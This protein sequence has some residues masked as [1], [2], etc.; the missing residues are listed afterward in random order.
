MIDDI[1]FY[2][3]PTRFIEVYTRSLKISMLRLEKNE[4]EIFKKLVEKGVTY[5]PSYE[6][7]ELI[8]TKAEFVKREVV[9]TRIVSRRSHLPSYGEV[10]CAKIRAGIVVRVAL[11][12]G[13]AYLHLDTVMYI[14]TVGNFSDAKELIEMRWFDIRKK[15]ENHIW[16]YMTKRIGLTKY[17]R[18]IGRET[19]MIKLEDGTMIRAPCTVYQCRLC[20]EKLLGIGSAMFHLYRHQISR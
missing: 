6:L 17:V 19:V 11:W 7:I 10:T 4:P 9:E 14:F 5:V 3:V 8:D 13:Y 16:R 12:F 15:I 2:P 20:G 18:K 1:R